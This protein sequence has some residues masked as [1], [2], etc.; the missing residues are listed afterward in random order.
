MQFYLYGCVP[1]ASGV[2]HD[3]QVEYVI[4]LTKNIKVIKEAVGWGT[5]KLLLDVW[6]L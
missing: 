4:I 5:S 3:C 1:Y 2:T 6:H